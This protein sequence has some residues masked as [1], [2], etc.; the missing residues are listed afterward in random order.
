MKEVESTNGRDDIVGGRIT[1]RRGDKHVDGMFLPLIDQRGNWPPTYVVEAAADERESTRSEIND[2]RGEIEL[3][4][5]PRFHGVQ[6]CRLDI[7]QVIRHQGAHMAVDHVI[8]DDVPAACPR[9]P[10][11]HPRADR[12][13]EHRCGCPCEDPTD[14]VGLG[15]LC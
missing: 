3:T 2:G 4:K 5:E 1:A 12:E 10:Q 15:G 7:E 13:D 9:P 14:R 8:S 11:R 6:I